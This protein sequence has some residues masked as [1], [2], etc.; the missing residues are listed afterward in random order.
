MDTL[1]VSQQTCII[2]AKSTKF[3]LKFHAQVTLV[4][5]SMETL[6]P[7]ATTKIQKD[8][9]HRRIQALLEFLTT[10][11]LYVHCTFWGQPASL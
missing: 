7:L 4:L 11:V 3:D 2:V 8:K 1:L 6:K 10:N 9:R 5:L